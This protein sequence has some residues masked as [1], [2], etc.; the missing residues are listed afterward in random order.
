MRTES[1]IHIRLK[2]QLNQLMEQEK[3]IILYFSSRDCNV[4]HAVFPKLMN[5][6]D[7]E[8]IDI[9]IIN[10]NEHVEI[11]GQLL[12]FTV[13]TILIFCEGKEILRESRFIDFQKVERI[14]NFLSEM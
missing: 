13:P 3:P 11:A 9:A 4:C 14:L 7:P 2:E 5:L 8:S 10:I 1:A 12:V 6:I